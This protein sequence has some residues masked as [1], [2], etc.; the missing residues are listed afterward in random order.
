MSRNHHEFVKFHKVGTHV[1][2]AMTDHGADQV[3]QSLRTSSRLRS[4][5]RRQRFVC[6]FAEDFSCMSGSELH[7]GGQE[8]IAQ[9]GLRAR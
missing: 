9:V 8:V 5:L 2:A 1:L 3:F 4:S 6:M 7:G